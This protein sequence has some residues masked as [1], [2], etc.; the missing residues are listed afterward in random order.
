[1]TKSVLTGVFDISAINGE[2]DDSNSQTDPSFGR[3]PV[4]AACLFTLSS[5]EEFSL[6][7]FLRQFPWG[8]AEAFR[9]FILYESDFDAWSKNPIVAALGED[10]YEYVT[11]EQPVLLDQTLDLLHVYSTM[12]H[13][14]K[15]DLQVFCA[16]KDR[17]FNDS[18]VLRGFNLC[19]LYTS[20]NLNENRELKT[21]RVFAKQYPTLSILLGWN[22]ANADY[23]LTFKGI[24]TLEAALENRYA[25]LLK[26]YQTLSHQSPIVP[27]SEDTE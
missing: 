2:L 19:P 9:L 14:L 4:P 16:N 8:I 22:K 24:N 1:M 18:G 15:Q 26:V 27:L 12:Q 11:D 6:F 5:K 7:E 25:F 20:S 13:Y 17:Y 21:R 3:E 23:Q 10:R